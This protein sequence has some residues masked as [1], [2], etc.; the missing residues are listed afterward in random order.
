MQV[1]DYKKSLHE[2]L[3]TLC[4]TLNSL[5]TFLPD[6]LLPA[7]TARAR[8]SP[9]SLEV[10]AQEIS[11]SSCNPGKGTCLFQA[12]AIDARESARTY[13]WCAGME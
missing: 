3:Q 2:Q 9:G 13:S 10:F 4:L 11:L 5:R 12:H 6:P 1:L 7:L 8:L